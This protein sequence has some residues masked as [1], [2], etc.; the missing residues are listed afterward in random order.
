MEIVLGAQMTEREGKTRPDGDQAGQPTQRD[1]VLIPGRHGKHG[2]GL[3]SEGSPQD[4]SPEANVPPTH[5]GD[6][7]SR[8]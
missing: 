4:Q 1:D 7:R 5:N 8:H 2:G 6:D 3:E